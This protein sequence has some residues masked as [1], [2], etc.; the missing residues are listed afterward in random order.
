MEVWGGERRTKEGVASA[1]LS[2]HSFGT[3]RV[4]KL[5]EYCWRLVMLGWFAVQLDFLGRQWQRC[6]LQQGLSHQSMW[7]LHGEGIL[8]MLTAY[9]GYKGEFA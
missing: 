7:R 2:R 5:L 3:S 9:F 4:L 1:M 6:F 8:M